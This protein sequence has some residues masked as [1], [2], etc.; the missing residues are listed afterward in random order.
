VVDE[1]V[2]GRI[3]DNEDDAVMATREVI[4]YDRA[5]VRAV[6]ERRFTA[7]VMA[8]RYVQLYDQ[9]VRDRETDLGLRMA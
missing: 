6:F 5:A 9:L 4:G 7:D 2:T 3:V 8:Q 1:H